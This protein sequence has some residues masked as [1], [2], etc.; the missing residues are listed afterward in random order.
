M[1][2][3]R[4]TL[5]T[6]GLAAAAAT[7]PSLVHAQAGNSTIKVALV[8]CGGRGT[9]AA[10]GLLNIDGIELV[11]VA[12]AFQDNAEN[13]AKSLAGSHAAKVKVT[14]ETTFHGFDAFKKAIDLADLVILATP[15]GFRPEHYEYAVKAGKHVFMEK[16][17]ATDA[18]GIRRIIEANKITEEKNLKVVVGL[19]R[20]YQ[21]S[22]LEALKQI[23]ED[24]LIGEIVALSCY[25][26]GR[27]PWVRA[28]DAQWSEMTFQMRNWYYFNWLCGDHIL[29]QHVHNIDVCNWFKGAVPVKARAVSGLQQQDLGPNH[30]E[31]WDHHAVEFEY[32]DGTVN[33][34]F[35]RHIP[36][37]WDDVSERI[38]GTTGR[39]S[40]AP[41]TFTHLR[42]ADRVNQY[43]GNR[44][45]DPYQQELNV[46]VDKIRKDEKHNDTIIGVEATM[47][48]ILGRMAGYSGKEL[49]LEDALA[50]GS[51]LLPDDTSGWNFESNPPV[52]PGEGGNYATPFP[53]KTNVF[54]G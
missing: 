3:R 27:R 26:N 44:D 14:P 40:L 48:G 30:G 23:K 54:E 8:G 21:Q 38:I 37:C 47:T 49:T 34:S 12:D 6:A 18:P 2:T 50:K 1:T 29:E 17:V 35:C 24:N 20:R 10:K 36:D 43:R 39:V 4:T 31:I 22:Y 33:H 45:A 41:G 46:L 19:Q 28:R 42:G 32:A 51:R 53:G 15:P 52:M 11:A 7:L 13:C 9:G 25:W 16:P 5:K